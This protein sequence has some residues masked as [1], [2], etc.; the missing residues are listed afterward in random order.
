ME[1]DLIEQNQEFVLPDALEVIQGQGGQPCFD[2]QTEA[3]RGR[4]YLLGATVTD[5]QPAGYQPVLF[6]S[7]E[8][9]FA[10]GEAI[11]GG[12]PICFPWFSDHPSEKGAPKHGLV[13]QRLWS[14]VQTG[15]GPDG[16]VQ[17]E[18]VYKLDLLHAHFRVEFGRELAMHLAV[19]NSS[20]SDQTF[21][22]ALHTYLSVGD[23]RHVSITGLEGV[24]YTDAL[25][26]EA[27]RQRDEGPITFDA[28]LDRVYHDTAD[29]CVLHDPGLGRRVTV[30]KT[31]GRSTIVWNPWIDKSRRMSGFGDDEWPVMCCIES[32]AVRDDAIT[33]GPGQTHTLSV[34]VS[35]ERA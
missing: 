32:A 6:T 35:V 26:P 8:S 23:V 10:D 19:T 30:A 18:M 31:G 7:A 28:E 17:T 2:L 20:D 13:R 22:A 1:A 16:Q 29:T 4:Q 14:P 9:A 34:N 15:K 25:R 3:C 5:W 27:G 21:E 33:L 24:G 12:V 11:H